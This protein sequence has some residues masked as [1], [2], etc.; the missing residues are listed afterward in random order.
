MEDRHIALIDLVP[1]VSLF[2][3]FDGHGGFEVA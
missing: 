1:G 3:I 2:G